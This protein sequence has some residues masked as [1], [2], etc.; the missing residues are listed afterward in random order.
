MNDNTTL[1]TIAKMA[2]TIVIAKSQGFAD[3]SGEF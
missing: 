2:G 1:K 3:L